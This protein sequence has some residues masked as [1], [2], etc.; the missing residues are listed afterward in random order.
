MV[1]P[2]NGS[3]GETPYAT[4]PR[5]SPYVLT[6]HMSPTMTGRRQLLGLARP[7]GA[8]ILRCSPWHQSSIVQI[9]EA[10]LASSSALLGDKATNGLDWNEQVIP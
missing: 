2:G 7:S 4:L 8:S 3:H 9:K 5:L 1:D 6:C 10:T